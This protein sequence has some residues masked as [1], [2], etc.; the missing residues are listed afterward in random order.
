[1]GGGDVKTRRVGERREGTYRG[2]SPHACTSYYNISY[3]AYELSESH[4][5]C[6]ALAVTSQYKFRPRC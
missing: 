1:M 2:T 6:R 5:A 3:K 4:F